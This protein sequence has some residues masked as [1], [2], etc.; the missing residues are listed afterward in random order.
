MS[1]SKDTF[2]ILPFVHFYTQADGE[3]K[4]CCIASGFDEK[5]SL[6]NNSIS[7]I[8]NSTE[9]KKLRKDMMCGKKNKVCNVC[10]LKEDRGEYSPRQMFNSNTLWSV[11][12]VKKDYSVPVEFQHIDIRFS[13][14][15]NFKCRMCN[16]GFSSNWFGDAKKIEVDGEFPY[17]SD[18]NTKV[19]KA[20][21]SIVDDIIP[22]LG[23]VKSFYFAGGEPLITPEHYKLL[24]WLYENVEDEITHL[25]THKALSIHYNTNL[26]VIKY[27]EDE[28]I[29]YWNSFRKVQLAISVDGIGE[30]GEYQR[31]GFK[32]NVFVKNLH[33]IQKH[34][35]PISSTAHPD[36]FCYSF[37][38]T[39]TILNIE[40]I[41][42]F[43]EF[44]L[45]YEFIETSE[46]IDFY[47]AWSPQWMG[48]NN[49]SDI[50]K[51]RITTLF[52]NRMGEINS[53]KTKNELTAIINYMNGDRTYSI[54]S[55]KNM[56][57]QLDKVNNTDYKK[58]LNLT[59]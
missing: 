9:Y 47:Y 28:L 2:C 53:E 14:L 22:H 55:V 11:P 39:T 18:K 24:M 10:Y 46:T 44:M 13:N 52:N 25:G 34:A 29:K 6:R 3:V 31:T 54:N 42:D 57:E 35:D 12:D 32:H 7:E 56:I 50:D 26:S 49:L 23:K 37:Q 20:S 1:Y 38:Y 27:D 36:G 16:H 40:H 21:E 43:I 19:L 4:P 41:F 17:L 48:V 30:I 59:F 15:C 33:E 5:Q 51:N 45:E 8:F 58:I